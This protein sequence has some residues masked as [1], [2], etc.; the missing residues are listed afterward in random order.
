LT[1]RRFREEEKDSL[2]G[3][4]VAERRRKIRCGIVNTQANHEVVRL[5]L[6]HGIHEEGGKTERRR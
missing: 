6:A 4:S 3:G 1:A 5:T 2:G